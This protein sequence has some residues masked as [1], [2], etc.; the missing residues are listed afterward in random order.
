MRL[1]QNVLQANFIL[2]K[3]EKMGVPFPREQP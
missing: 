2:L 1:L 3:D